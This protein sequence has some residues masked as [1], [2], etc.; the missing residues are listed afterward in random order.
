MRVALEL[1]VVR[2]Q[3]DFG[4]ITGHQARNRKVQ[5]DGGPQG[6]QVETETPI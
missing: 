1:L 6:H 4:G 3:E 2:G 5:R